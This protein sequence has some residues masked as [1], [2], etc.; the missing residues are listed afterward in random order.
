MKTFAHLFDQFAS[1]ENLLV[2]YE[3]AGRGKRGR[4]YVRRF[5]LDLVP[6]DLSA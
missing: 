4:A 2:A 5:D 1:F 3:K 6:S